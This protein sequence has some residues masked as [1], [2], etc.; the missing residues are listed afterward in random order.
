MGTK[1]PKVSAYVPQVL[2]DRLDEFIKE[3]NNIP[4][5]QAVNIILAEYFGMTEVLN[6][7]LENAVVGGVTL[8][9]ME[10]L[11][12]KLT[13][14]ATLVDCRLQKLGEEIEKISRS[15]VVHHVTSAQI[16]SD[17]EQDG[18]LPNEPLEEVP[19]QTVIINA[20]ERNSS[21]SEPTSEPP[22]EQEIDTQLNSLLSEPLEELPTQPDTGQVGEPSSVEESV[23]LTTG[24]DV[25]ETS[26]V[27]STNSE[28]LVDHQEMALGEDSVSGKDSSPGSELPKNSEEALP[29][30]S[31][32]PFELKSEPPIEFLPLSSVKLSKRFGKGDQAVK[33]MRLKYGDDVEKFI[34]WNRG[35]DPDKIAWEHMSKGYVPLGELTQEQRANLQ[36]WYKENS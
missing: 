31:E 23:N 30:H 2:K 10:A 9:R 21:L 25:S 20:G 12:E 15:S 32:L 33:R 16:A 13:D 6:R 1:N 18:S 7:S 19:D 8:G 34:E 29:H 4:E 27:S 26:E 28:L 14:L 24:Q 35:Q 17:G 11:E 36:K 5:S 3:R 22:K